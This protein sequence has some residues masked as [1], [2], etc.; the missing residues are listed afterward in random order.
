[1]KFVA[2]ALIVLAQRQPCISFWYC[3]TATVVR[4]RGQIWKQMLSL[5]L[6]SNCRIQ[7]IRSFRH[8]PLEEPLVQMM[9][10]S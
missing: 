8:L 1:V 2:N 7:L 4:Q 9:G 6:P 3:K 5:L 10:R